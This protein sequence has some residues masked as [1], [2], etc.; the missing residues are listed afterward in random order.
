MP[1]ITL[2]R[3]IKEKRGTLRKCRE[4][5]DPMETAKVSEPKKVKAPTFLNKYGKAFFES[6]R[7]KLSESFVLTETDIETLELLSAEYGKY[8]EAQ[9]KLKKE[10]YVV[11][12]TNKNGSSYEMVS[13]WVNI[14]NN[15][16]KNYNSLMGKFGLSPSERQK[17][18][19]IKNEEVD[20]SASLD[21]FLSVN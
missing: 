7:D 1:S 18:S 13:P 14:A 8:V 4:L 12:G 5:D 17:I 20:D 6:Y 15:A 11:N 21:D 3:E 9:Y 2:P 16:F 10:G 19:K